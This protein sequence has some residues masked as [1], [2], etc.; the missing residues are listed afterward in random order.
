MSASNFT[1]A[2]IEA[3]HD[4]IC[5]PGCG[6]EVEASGLEQTEKQRSHRLI[7][8]EPAQFVLNRNF[9]HDAVEIEAL[10]STIRPSPRSGRGSRSAATA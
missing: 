4:F 1:I 3:L 8:I 6:I 7:E 9:D 10:S 5:K 2:Q